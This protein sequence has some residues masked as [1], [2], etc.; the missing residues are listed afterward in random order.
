M[1]RLTIVCPAYNE[2]EGILAFYEALKAELAKLGKR[3]SADILFVVDGGSDGTFDILEALGKRDSHVRVIRFSRNFGHQMALLAGLD[4]AS[5]DIVITMDSDLQHPPEVIQQ[6]LAE[7]EKGND[8]VYTVRTSIEGGSA[9]RRIVGHIFYRFFQFLSDLP[10]NEN[11]ADFR[12]MSRR[13]VDIIRND[14]RE[15]TLFLR[16]LVSWMGFRQSS[17]SFTARRR[18]AGESHYSLSKLISFAVMGTVSFSK[19]PLRLA[20]FAG[21]I[22]ASFGFIYAIITIIQYLIGEA[23]PAGWATVTVLLSIFSGTQLIFLGILGEYI[24]VIFDEAKAR[25][26]Y[27]VEDAVN[28]E[29]T[30]R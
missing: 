2:A 20:T 21:F 14:I 4:H 13:A 19:K 27:I 8:I 23:F 28:I 7:Y 5:G 11:A 25:P 1:K 24:G 18:F 10:I 3:Y 9:M 26:H 22:F 15:R 16:G 29:A 30:T 12:L 17:V 6:L